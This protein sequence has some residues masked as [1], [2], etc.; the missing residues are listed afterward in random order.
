M[1]FIFAEF[2][3]LLPA[4]VLFVFEISAHWTVILGGR[5]GSMNSVTGP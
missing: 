3:F 2:E 1:G 4:S 5:F